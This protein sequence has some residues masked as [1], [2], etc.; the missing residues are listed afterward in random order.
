[1][2]LVAH[3]EYRCT[4]LYSLNLSHLVSPQ[5][6]LVSYQLAL[7]VLADQGRSPPRWYEDGHRPLKSRCQLVSAPVMSVKEIKFKT[8]PSFEPI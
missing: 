6:T 5:D 2:I 7:R 8:I 4:L 1:M 3:E